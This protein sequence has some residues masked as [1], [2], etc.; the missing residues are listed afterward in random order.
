MIKKPETPFGFLATLLI[1]ALLGGIVGGGLTVRFMKLSTNK[2]AES[3]RVTEKQV[4]VEDS[5]VIQTVKKISPSVVSVVI[6][7]DLPLY[8]ERVFNFNDPFFGEQLFNVPEYDRDESGNIKRELTKIGGGSGFIVTADG[9]VVT[10]GHVVSD[11]EAEYTVITNDQKEYS[12]EVIS[13]DSIN[14]I[15]ILRMKNANGSALDSLPVAQLGDSDKLQI[16]Q[17]VVA[18][19]NALAEYENTVTTGVI[20]AKGRSINA[21]T[22]QSTESLIN[23]IQTDAAINPGNSGGPLVNLDG[24][25][26]GINTAIAAGA[27]GI[28]FAIPVNDIKSA[29][30]SVK[31]YG[32]IVRP[33]LGVRFL[34]LDADKAKELQI[35]VDHGALLTGDEAAGEFAVVPASPAD[36]AGLQMKDVIL[37][38][39]GEKVTTENPLHVIVSKKKPGDE[40]TLKVWRSGED[41]YQIK[42]YG[43]KIIFDIH[44]FTHPTQIPVIPITGRDALQ[45]VSTILAIG[46]IAGVSKMI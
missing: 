11:P 12:A 21:G 38:V 31:A 16:G 41:G 33:Y 6:S 20:S 45:R 7:K 3:T 44:Y 39:D 22:I 13:T 27:Q 17:K 10:N 42:T 28:G 43:S 34:M 9:L 1:I 19:G 40:I 15:A 24:E 36:K 2:S 46:L 37:E 4:Y 25:V 23:L 5:Q 29:V 32:K 18:I 26:I 30:E 35:D 8:K 14:D